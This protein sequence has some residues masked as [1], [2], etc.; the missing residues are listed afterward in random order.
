MVASLSKSHFTFVVAAMDEA[1]AASSP[2][3]DASE[4]P[5]SP[6]PRFESGSES[7]PR[8]ASRRYVPETDDGSS[9]SIRSSC[10]SRGAPQDMS[11]ERPT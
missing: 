9:C 7:R 6:A 11:T 8:C 10:A 1:C 3:A 5:S 4:T 2:S